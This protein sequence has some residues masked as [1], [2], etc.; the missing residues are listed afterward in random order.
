MNRGTGTGG[1]GGG[2]GSSSTGG[3]APPGSGNIMAQSAAITATGGVGT[4]EIEAAQRAAEVA[5]SHRMMMSGA[6]SMEM[7]VAMAGGSGAGSGSGSGAGSGNGGGGPAGL[8]HQYQPNAGNAAAVPYVLNPDGTPLLDH[9]YRPVPLQKILQTRPLKADV[10]TRP[11]PGNMKLIYM[12]GEVVT[13]TLNE[14]FG[15]GGWSMEVREK[16][17]EQCDKDPKGRYHVHYTATVRIIHVATGSYREDVGA[18]DS[19]DKSLGTAV[20]HAMKGAVTDA[21]K[22][23]AR[24]FGEKLGNS[25][26][27]SKF[28]LQHAPVTL[29]QALETYELDRNKAT[30]FEKDRTRLPGAAA[31]T[32]TCTT[33]MVKME[34]SATIS[35]A[36]AAA[37]AAPTRRIAAPLPPQQMHHQ[38][39]HHHQQQP[40]PAETSRG[41]LYGKQP[42]TIGAGA[43]GGL[44]VVVGRT[45]GNGP[46]HGN[47]GGGRPSIGAAAAQPQPQKH[48]PY[49]PHPHQARAA[50]AVATTGATGSTGSTGSTANVAATT[51]A[52]A[53]APAPVGGYPSITPGPGTIAK[54]QQQQQQQATTTAM[55]GA[56]QS[57]V[58]QQ[59]TTPYGPPSARQN[60]QQSGLFSQYTAADGNGPSNA[61]AL[62][63]VTMTS[64]IG[65]AG[66][67]SAE[68][69]QQEM[70]RPGTSRG[71]S[72]LGAGGNGIGQ[73][74]FASQQQHHQSQLHVQS[75][76]QHAL[77]SQSQGV[78]RQLGQESGDANKR[79]ALGAG[80]TTTGGGPPT[81]ASNPYNV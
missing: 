63:D 16:N 72:S 20:A 17:R 24:H 6:A 70:A 29:R 54:V 32:G 77:Q 74:P 13:R 45:P 15:F 40:K 23:A 42:G 58:H 22:R 34:P 26:Y 53:P 1:G 35:T 27:D 49:T 37:A 8:T 11:G 59:T 46:L 7:M 28:K 57:Q 80:A 66:G 62:N 61:A 73:P 64:N 55:V 71:R 56:Q 19:I 12:S 68:Q 5:L 31:G 75:Q 4:A 30:F 76:H 38:Q 69:Q 50:A 3:G 39:Q 79:P 36:V 9:H 43:G 78:K 2:R 10:S 52:P 33:A 81:A 41:P 48:M 21:M 18:N 67:G 51:T 14:L 47:T 25:L 60:L 65:G 44:G